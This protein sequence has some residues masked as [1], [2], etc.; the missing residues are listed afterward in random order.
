M[1]TNG[2]IYHIELSLLGT[3]QLLNCAT[4]VAI[5]ELINQ[6][7]DIKEDNI[8]NGLRAVKWIGRLEIMRNNPQL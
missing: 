4:A 6:N 3:H 1:K 7:I 5:E 8:L 2:N